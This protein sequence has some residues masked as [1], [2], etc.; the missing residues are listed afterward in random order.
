MYQQIWRENSYDL[1]R[2]EGDLIGVATTEEEARETAQRIAEEAPG[3]I[4]EVEVA[5]GGYGVTAV[6]MTEEEERRWL[7]EMELPHW[8]HDDVFIAEAW[9]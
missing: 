9:R 1:L 2:Q 6:D 7:E 5:P 8:L 3:L 4:L